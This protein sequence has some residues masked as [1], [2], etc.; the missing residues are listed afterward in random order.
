MW[1]WICHSPLDLVA[2]GVAGERFAIL[3]RPPLQHPGTAPYTAAM[4]LRDF[5][6]EEIRGGFVAIGNF[7]GVHRGHRRMAE[8]LVQRAR[9]GDV[10]AVVLTFDPHPIEL[11][12][13]GQ[14]P[15]RLSTLNRKTELLTAI[16]VDFVV[17]YP[18]DRELLSLTPAEFF[19]QFI[20]ARLDARGLVEGPNF[21]F[22]KDRAGNIETLRTMCDAAGLS[23]DVVQPVTHHEELVSSSVIRR[24]VAEGDVRAAAD[25][26]GHAYQ[27]S[28]IVGTGD[29]R[30]R[31]LGFPTANL[32]EVPTLLPGDGVYATHAIVGGAAHKAAVNIGPNPT[33]GGDAQKVEAHLLDHTGDLYAQPLA[34]VFKE[35]IRDVQTFAGVDEL[36]RQLQADIEQVRNCC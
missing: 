14:V 6:H 22:G 27:I 9:A 18:T 34:L 32:T 24:A 17:A 29:G 12:R 16:G 31:T 2:Y 20:R 8:T 33:F 1:T 25:L 36:K 21:F 26:L 35:R 4:L 3:V 15:P 7:D 23:L 10:A 13:P 11:L 28:G 30:G 19:E 5:D